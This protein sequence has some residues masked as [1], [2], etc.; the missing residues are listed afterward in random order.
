[1]PFGSACASRSGRC[2]AACPLACDRILL[3]RGRFWGKSAA[4]RLRPSAAGDA[5]GGHRLFAAAAVR[6]A[7]RRSAAFS[8]RFGVVFAFRWTGAALASAVMG[9]PLMV[10]A[11]RLSLEAVDRRL[12]EAAGDAWR[13]RA[14]GVALRDPAADDAGHRRRHDPLLRPQP[15]RIRRDDHLCLEHSR[16]DP[17]PCRLAIY[18]L[19]QV[20]GGD[21][22][23]LRLTL[24][25]VGDLA[26][27]ADRLRA[28]GAR[29]SRRTSGDLTCSSV[30]VKHRLGDFAL[31]T[32][33]R[34]G[35]V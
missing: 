7:R 29:T 19:T 32:G 2:W 26:G 34:A 1:M 5:A 4:R 33:S 16:R 12:E 9:F 22:A 6:P 8:P 20:P 27:G 23:A 24:V 15:R 28:A 13:R 35:P 31:D 25:S 30:A 14:V 3:A 21:P 18:T 17:D 11:M 10:R